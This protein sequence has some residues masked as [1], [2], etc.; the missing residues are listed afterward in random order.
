[1]DKLFGIS[2]E[3]WKK[4]KLPLLD[5]YPLYGGPIPTASILFAYVAFV[6]YLGPKLMKNRKP[7]N[8]KAIIILYNALQVCYNYFAWHVA[9]SSPL[10]WK[11]FLSFGCNITEQEYQLCVECFCRVAWH[12]M[13]A[14]LLDLL[15]TVFFILCKKQSKITFLHVQHHFLTV[16]ILWTCTKYY[17]GE[18]FSIVLLCN[19]LVHVVMYFYYFLA[20]LGP[21]YKKYIWWKKHLTLVQIV[22]FVVIIAYSTASLWLSCGYNQTVILLIIANV[23][24]NLILFLNFFFNTYGS[25]KLL[26]D[27][28]AVCGSL[29]FNHNYSENQPGTSSQPDSAKR[30]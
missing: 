7:Y 8:L 4:G 23:S 6:L 17:S 15:D 28:V 14:R 30:D 22:Q 16:A 5:T 2:L 9:V 26:A 29:Q 18:E 13:M 24:L 12:A 20:A 1:M 19:N 21:E 10:F 11:S 25:G 3:S 27:K